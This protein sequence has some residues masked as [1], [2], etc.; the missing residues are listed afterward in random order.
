[1]TPK[2]IQHHAR[3]L[4]AR[5]YPSTT[6]AVVVEVE[7]YGQRRLYPITDA[8]DAIA[9]LVGART[10]DDRHLAIAKRLGVT[11]RVTTMAVLAAVDPDAA[12]R[13]YQSSAWTAPRHTLTQPIA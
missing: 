10:L 1:M 13:F 8:A 3:A 5:F 2:Q 9:A 12:T 7:S 11:P 4:V 6:D